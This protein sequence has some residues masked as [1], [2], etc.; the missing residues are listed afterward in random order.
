MRECEDLGY[1]K[2]LGIV[3]TSNV[4]F[5]I[6]HKAE[7]DY[8]LYIGMASYTFDIDN[9]DDGHKCTAASQNI[10]CAAAVQANQMTDSALCGTNSR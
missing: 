1:R 10:P 3:L 9:L 2:E 4:G 7:M 5:P 8:R 6:Y